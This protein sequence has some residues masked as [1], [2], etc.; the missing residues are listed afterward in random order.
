VTPSRQEDV[1]DDVID[2]GTGDAPSDER[3]YSAD[4]R[5][6]ESGEPLFAS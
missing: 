3:G 4:G 1:G 6:E 2:L 5:I